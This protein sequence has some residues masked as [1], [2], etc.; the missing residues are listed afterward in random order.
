MLVF[1][2]QNSGVGGIA[3]CNPRR[4]VFCVAVEY[5][6]YCVEIDH[7]IPLTLCRLHINVYDQVITNG[8]CSVISGAGNTIRQ[9]TK[10]K[11]S[12]A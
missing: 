9:Q 5:R 4:Q 11:D 1:S 10:D 6:L 12:Q 3:H 8:T 7:S 2:T